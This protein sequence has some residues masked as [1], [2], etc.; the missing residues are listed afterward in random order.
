MKLK[1]ISIFAILTLY[2][3]ITLCV[4]EEPKSYFPPGDYYRTGNSGLLTISPLFEGL[5]KFRIRSTGHNAHA[6]GLNGTIESGHVQV[7]VRGI[8][9]MSCD[10]V[11][12]LNDDRIT[13]EKGAASRDCQ[14]FCGAAAG[15]TGTY[16]KPSPICEPASI[17]F[18]DKQVKKALKN[19]ETEK[20]YWI[21]RKLITEC[22]DMFEGFGYLS[23]VFHTAHLSLS[24]KNH[25]CKKILEK[26]SFFR[27]L[28]REYLPEKMQ[29]EYD[30][31]S[32]EFNRLESE[33]EQSM[34]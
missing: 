21:S 15:F 17:R 16:W 11:F 32:T 25:Q 12:K 29:N 28:K 30:K 18:N 7:D 23:R 10:V 1:S 3:N 5:Q 9:D 34:K 26:G 8:G 2:Y 31:Y 20:G 24:A 22:R 4:A 13:I 6:C 19:N 14:G 33:C 27:D